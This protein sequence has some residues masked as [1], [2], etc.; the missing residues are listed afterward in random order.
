MMFSRMI[1]LLFRVLMVN[2]FRTAIIPVL[3]RFVPALADFFDIHVT[4]LEVLKEA[5][6]QGKPVDCI[7]LCKKRGKWYY[8]Y[9]VAGDAADLDL[10]SACWMKYK[11]TIF[12]DGY[13]VKEQCKSDV[14]K[15]LTHPTTVIKER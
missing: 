9:A 12:N 10:F 5:A 1:A 6:D 15:S 11:R 4:A 2:L 7:F 13:I 14:M 3:T 8:F